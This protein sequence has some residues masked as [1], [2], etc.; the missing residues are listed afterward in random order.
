VGEGEFR[1]ERI[2]IKDLLSFASHYL[3]HADRGSMIPI[4]MQRAEAHYH[5]PYADGDDVALLA[6]Y[7]GEELVGYFGIMQVMLKDGET[8]HKAHWFSTWL[9][10]PKLRGRS[11]G[12]LLME[13]A[14]SL[15]QDYLIVGS[16]PAR[17]V[18][19]KFGFLERQPLE[20]YELDL[21]GTKKLNPIVALLRLLRKLLHPFK[22]NVEITNPLTRGFERVIGRL[23]KGAFTRLLL[24]KHAARL[25]SISFREVAEVRDE[26]EAQWR[27]LP[28]VTLYRSPAVV[29]WMLKYPWQVE[30]GKSRTEHLGYYFSD[31]RQLFRQIALEITSPDGKEYKGYIVFSVSTIRSDIVLKLMDIRLASREDERA[32]LPLVLKYGQ[33]FHADRIDLP[34]EQ[35]GRLAGGFLKWALLHRKF[36]VTQCRP[37]DDQSPLARAW[38]GLRLNYCDGD[39]AFS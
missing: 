32:V 18:C 3:D 16:G 22:V 4:S 30:P 26:T 7:D 33:A 5:N 34:Q 28:G 11:V 19:R 29:N 14:L 39:M 31:V 36:R 25:R 27:N 13:E 35:A 21:T 9:V 6:A 38:P 10:S 8:L 20:Y 37:K 15:N 23:T 17:Q 12:S 24:A 2:K 1:I